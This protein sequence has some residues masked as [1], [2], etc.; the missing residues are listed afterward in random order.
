M[1]TSSNVA[2]LRC[3]ACECTHSATA[4]PLRPGRVLP[5]MMAMRMEPPETVLGLRDPEDHLAVSSASRCRRRT[6]GHGFP[7]FRPI[8]ECIHGRAIH[9]ELA[10]LD[11]S[12]NAAHAFRNPTDVHHHSPY[13][14]H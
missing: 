10:F 2:S 11:Q 5:M 3:A 14:V 7:C 9:P 1:S 4:S 8:L 12:A 13:T 6:S